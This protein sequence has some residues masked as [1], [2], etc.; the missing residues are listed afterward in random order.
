MR[1]VT[2]AL[3]LGSLA[4]TIACR[5]K[6][7]AAMSRADSAIVTQRVARLETALAQ[8]DSGAA[9]SPKFQMEIL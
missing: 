7:G 5:P 1:P 4:A 3:L 6:A 8:P 2:Q 9:N